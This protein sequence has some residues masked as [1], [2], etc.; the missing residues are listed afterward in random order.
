MRALTSLL[1][2]PLDIVDRQHGRLFLWLPVCFAV[3]IGL[4]FAQS[5]EPSRV[6]LWALAGAGALALLALRRMPPR[7]APLLIAVVAVICGF[8]NAGLRTHLV[9]EPVLG[10][11]YYGPVEGRV[12]KI[13]RSASDALRLTLDEVVLR[14]VSPER[15]PAR[16][17]VSLHGRQDFVSPAPGMRLAMTAHLSPPP[18]PTEPG[19]FDFQR[20]AWFDRLGAVGY[21]RVPV[22]RVAESDPTP[23]L[24][25]HQLR[26][27]LS[28][29][30][31]S[32]LSGQIG[33]FSAA[34]LTG[35]R[36]GISLGTAEALRGANLSHLLAISGLHM[37]LLT[38]AVFYALRL[39]L[40]MIP[41]AA[42][43]WPIKKIAAAGALAAGGFYLALSGFN[44]AT[45][46]AFVM[47]SVMLVAVLLDRQAISLRAV[48]LAALILLLIQ[49]E[50]L[51]EPGFQ[52]SFAATTALVAVFS[53]VRRMSLMTRWPR[54]LRGLATV[55]LSSA[56]AGIA[57]APV[58]AAH[59]NRISDYG[60]IANV[61]AVP[62]MGAVVMP[63]AVLALLLT[64]FGLQGLALAVMGQGI[65]WIL[66][67]AGTV[68]S[69]EG[70]V[71]R[72]AAPP[73]A[74]LPLIALGGVFVILWRGRWQVLGVLPV[75]A[76]F[77]L[78]ALHERPA[79]LVSDDGGLVG[80]FSAEGRALSKPKGAGFAARV[81]LENDGDRPDQA[82]A[83]AR[84]MPP[85]DVAGVRI[86]HVTGRGWQE[87]AQTACRHADLVIVNKVWEGAR[88]EPCLVID[89]AVLR[90]S[91]ALAFREERG[92]LWLD[93]A[94]GVAGARYWNTPE[95]REGKAVTVR[96]ARA[97]RPPV[98][99]GMRFGAAEAGEVRLAQ[100]ER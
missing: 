24:W 56:V 44:V 57:T 31:Q 2:I 12:I 47:V 23:L 79:L 40:A 90:Q 42:L 52:M 65:R 81:W 88:P 35:D 98:A 54:W 32:R 93:T 13:D 72:I 14:D 92:A 99:L 73:P 96:E 36:S 30:L 75:A 84:P 43:T 17:R 95:L 11:R 91:G 8:V 19:G 29:A 63:S 76:G 20:M 55:V 4:F 59:F 3:G 69:W 50:V 45:E 33:A 22:L 85:L 58:A 9:A 94:Y 77:L 97:K 6:L 49:P 87:A 71:S 62:V 37:G 15:V 53:I 10:F 41:G 18:G 25:V 16:V 82:R 68:S 51:P 1:Q 78:W 83:A 86:K 67:V 70:A 39:M 34:I 26:Q 5:L 7:A 28:T 48:A 38:G 61:T 27:S 66:F 64:P 60:L 89:L 21:T 74:T 100:R 80:R 46:R